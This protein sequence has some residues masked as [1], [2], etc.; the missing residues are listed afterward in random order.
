[1][2]AEVAALLSAATP[3]PQPGSLRFL[4]RAQGRGQGGAGPRGQEGPQKVALWGFPA[5]ASAWACTKGERDGVRRRRAE[6]TPDDFSRERD[7]AC[8]NP[9][10]TRLSPSTL[11]EGKKETEVKVLLH[12]PDTERPCARGKD[13]AQPLATD[14]ILF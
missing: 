10:E 3:G 8:Q 6:Q 13:G 7:D 1:M 14:L 5:V 2:D 9:V 11:R 12:L 4:L